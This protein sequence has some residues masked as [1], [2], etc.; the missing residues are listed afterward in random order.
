MSREILIELVKVIPTILW[1]LFIVVILII[2][3]R[4]IG[5]MLPRTSGFK[6]FGLELTF[7]EER[8]D[9]ASEKQAQKISKSSEERLDLAT[10]RREIAISEKDR[11]QLF[12]RLSWVA[13][14]LEGAQILWVD[15]NPENNIQETSILRSFG[16]IVDQAESTENALHML[17][18]KKYDAIISDMARNGVSDEGLRFVA[19]M[20]K[21]DM[22]QRTIFYVG[23]FFESERLPAGAFAI[24]NRP[25]HLLH[26]VLDALERARG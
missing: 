12:K 6:A 5:R 17:G 1:I 3:R 15:D 22:H 9:R 7:F 23:L 18:K 24:T 11:S 14:I 4:Y 16:I 10:A 13:P 21:R 2:Y 8:L 19:E 26:Y 20:R 25:D